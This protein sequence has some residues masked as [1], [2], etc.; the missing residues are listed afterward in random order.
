MT[1]GTDGK[2]FKL[3]RSNRVKEKKSYMSL[4]YIVERH[5][6]VK[7]VLEISVGSALESPGEGGAPA[8]VLSALDIPDVSPL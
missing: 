2:D 3:E 6:W 4:W 7:N 8:T 5:A 1:V